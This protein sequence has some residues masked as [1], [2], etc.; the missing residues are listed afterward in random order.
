MIHAQTE[1]LIA[2]FIFHLFKELMF[3]EK[4]IREFLRVGI[5]RVGLWNTHYKARI[6]KA[7]DFIFLF[8]YFETL[9][10]VK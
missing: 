9:K 8:Y 1:V 3:K 7:R 4:L 6:M 10:S 5:L 2:I